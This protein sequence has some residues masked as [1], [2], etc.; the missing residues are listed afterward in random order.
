MVAEAFMEEVAAVSKVAEF[1][2]VA[3]M[4]AVLCQRRGWAEVLRGARLARLRSQMADH[5]EDPEVM[6][7]TQ[8]GPAVIA[9]ALASITPTRAR[10]VRLRF[11]QRHLAFLLARMV[12][13]T[14]SV[15]HR[16]ATRPRIGLRGR[17]PLPEVSP[18]R[19]TKYTRM[20]RLHGMLFPLVVLRQTTIRSLG[21]P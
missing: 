17:G 10:E 21:I 9:L 14:H 13:G 8:A 2:A 19:D 7:L 12:S 16:L 6:L 1:P 5:T 15:V 18:D 3:A 4:E 20:L 11:P